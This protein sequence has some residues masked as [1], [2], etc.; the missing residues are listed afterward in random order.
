MKESENLVTSF[1]P[2]FTEERQKHVL[3]H[4]R[5]QKLALDAHSQGQKGSAGGD[6][7]VL[8]AVF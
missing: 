8:T 5:H 1:L 2:T 6:E 7:T 3:R 4:Q